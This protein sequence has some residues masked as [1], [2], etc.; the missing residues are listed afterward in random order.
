VAKLKFKA[1]ILH[2]E[3]CGHTKTPKL[4]REKYVSI[5]NCSAWVLAGGGDARVFKKF[6]K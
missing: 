4:D 2:S 5:L 1:L 3:I 6:K